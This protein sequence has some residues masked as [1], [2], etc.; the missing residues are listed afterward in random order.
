MEKI[1][2]ISGS[3]LS[4]AFVPVAVLLLLILVP[5]STTIDGMAAMPG[6]FVDAL[7]EQNLREQLTPAVFSALVAALPEEIVFGETTIRTAPI[8]SAIER[9]GFGRAA[10]RVLPADWIQ[11]L[12]A[13]VLAR[14]VD[15]A[16]APAPAS[17]FPQLEKLRAQLVGTAAVELA[18]LIVDV[19]RACTD[20]EVASLRDLLASGARS[21][22]VI[23][24][25]CNPPDL[26][27]ID[28][29]S[30]MRDIVVVALAGM[31]EPIAETARDALGR[32]ELEQLS[33]A[34]P[35]GQVSLVWPGIRL[36]A[37]SWAFIY[38]LP[39]ETQLLVE[40]RVA[41]LRAAFVNAEAQA[42]QTVEETRASLEA[43]LPAPRPT[44]PPA[45]E[46]SAAAGLRLTAG[47]AAQGLSAFG[48][49]LQQ[50]LE[51]IAAGAAALSGTLRLI[52]GLLLLFTTAIIIH[53]L[54][55]LRGIIA[56]IGAVF[57]IS[58][59]GLLIALS[60]G[61]GSSAAAPV[62]SAEAVQSAADLAGLIRATFTQAIAQAA[63]QQITGPLQAQ[64]IA[65]TAAGAALL[66]ALLATRLLR[67]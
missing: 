42:R 20:A 63:A 38:F 19:A 18:A 58:G 35:L 26:Q 17:S 29:R 62:T 22:V 36:A 40:A 24:F 48:E 9:L 13:G 8:V 45:P 53:L 7:E 66:I 49:W 2:R 60:A 30:L 11:R 6:A 52:S 64:A 37:G 21:P 27:D 4:A 50:A 23:T 56:W 15:R 34:T 61:A 59:I 16:L 1:L 44:E 54:R 10:Q 51:D 57:L 47:S 32:I 46:P 65:L 33:V 41:E 5:V 67:N 28:L 43:L 31:A 12:A 55:T 25:I 14:A 3:I 39:E